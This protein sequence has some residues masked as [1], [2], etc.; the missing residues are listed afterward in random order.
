[1]QVWGWGCGLMGTASRLEA[2]TLRIY[3]NN[4]LQHNSMSDRDYAFGTH[5][6]LEL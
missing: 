4:E 3:L 2:P 1:M 5:A 6:E